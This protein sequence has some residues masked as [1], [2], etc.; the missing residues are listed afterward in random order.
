M[1]F[2]LAGNNSPLVGLIPN[3]RSLFDVK[4]ASNGTGELLKNKEYLYL[5]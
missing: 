4:N 5:I 1:P 3:A 2:K